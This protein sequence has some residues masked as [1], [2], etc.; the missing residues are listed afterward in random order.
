MK[1][2]PHREC[3]E[4]CIAEGE[5]ASLTTRKEAH[6][7]RKLLLCKEQLMVAFLRFASKL[8]FE[9]HTAT[10]PRILSPDAFHMKEDL[11]SSVR[12]IS[13]SLL[14]F[15]RL[16]SKRPAIEIK[17]TSQP[18]RAYYIGIEGLNRMTPCRTRKTSMEQNEFCFATASLP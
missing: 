2:L 15:S 5:R 13:L 3:R 4:S 7:V 1:I 11:K 6:F 9:L 8:Q 14:H 17:F 18:V 10:S 12:S 16:S